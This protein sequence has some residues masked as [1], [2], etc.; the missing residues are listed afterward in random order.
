MNPRRKFVLAGAGLLFLPLQ[1]GAQGRLPRI[2][3]LTIR[4]R[5]HAIEAA[6]IAGLKD[7]GYVEGK[8]IA[9]EWRYADG[10]AKR[11]PGLAA[12]LVA[13][14]PALIV[15]ASTQAIEAAG[16]ATK[17]I[18]IVFPANA[19]PVGG[20][21]VKSLSRP[22]GNITGLSTIAADLGA[23]Q[24]E[25]LRAVVPRLASIA[26]L[27]NPTNAG[28]GL[29][30]KDLEASARKAGLTVQMFE[31]QTPEAIERAFT[32]MA[33]ARMGAVTL[34]I[35]GFFNQATKQIVALALKHRLPFISTQSLD[36][37]AGSL[38]SYGAALTDNYRRAAIYI[39][40]ILKGAKPADLPV[41]QPLAVE[42]V[43]NLKTAKALGLAIPPALRVRADRV[44]E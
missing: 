14:K 38:M 37:E 15:A 19:D 40:K 34:A 12:E 41:E 7:L 4:S 20:G 33:A 6:L 1:A 16:A 26:V 2:G 24:I 30:V 44:I 42:L 31:A 28:S 25:L 8:T 27:V 39:D 36:A 29:V 11:L 17:T 9:I 10:D 21:F 32:A 3:V 18:P 35:D 43:L 13:L 5:G 23:K 22:G